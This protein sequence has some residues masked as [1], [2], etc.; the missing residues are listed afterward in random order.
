MSEDTSKAK[1]LDKEY[2]KF[3]K[4]IT[5]IEHN[6]TIAI[7]KADSDDITTKTRQKNINW[8]E[9]C[10]ITM[11]NLI[12]D[13]YDL[14]TINIILIEHIVD[15]LDFNNILLLYKYLFSEHVP[16]LHPVI[17]NIK[18]YLDKSIIKTKR[19][20][21]IIL[22]NK[23]EEK[24]FILNNYKWTPATPLQKNELLSSIKTN[25]YFI[26]DST[27]LNT[28]MGYISYDE[29]YDYNFKIK[30]NDFKRHTGANCDQMNKDKKVALLNTLIG[31]EKYKKYDKSVPKEKRE[32][33]TSGMIKE[34]LCS[35]IEFIMRYYSKERKDD[36]IWFLSNDKYILNK[37]DI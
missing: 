12:K 32:G 10:G 19:L 11:K 26:I 13:G 7:E 5:E 29:K 14:N 36:R 18:V 21:G 4:L 17:K 37:I 9:Q 6:Y 16:E 22:F 28:I 31:Y 1:D 2:D 25:P 20:I 15:M 34:Q 35:L 30:Y 27:K 8:Y 23:N 24:M 33:D 3:I